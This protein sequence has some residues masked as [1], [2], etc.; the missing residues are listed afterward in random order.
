MN[1]DN[2]SYYVTSFT[3]FND[4]IDEIMDATD[5]KKYKKISKKK[6]LLMEFNEELAINQIKNKTKK[7]K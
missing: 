1:K 4:C 5:N 3:N 6:Q 2:L 7:I